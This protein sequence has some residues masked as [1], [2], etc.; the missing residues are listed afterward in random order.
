MTIITRGR[1]AIALIPVSL[2]MLTA[3][4]DGG[5]TDAGPTPDEVVADIEAEMQAAEIA[6][7][8]SGELTEAQ[9]FIDRVAAAGGLMV[10]IADIASRDAKRDDVKAYVESSIADHR[11][12]LASLKA[13]MQETSP[14]LTMNTKGDAFEQAMAEMRGA[15]NADDMYLKKTR[16]ARREFVAAIDDYLETGTYPALVSWAKDVKITTEAHGDQLAKL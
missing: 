7:A 15:L 10:G 2:L 8:N 14:D 4:G 11:L 5:A 3:C 13:A 6:V 9:D 1:T 12:M 16:A